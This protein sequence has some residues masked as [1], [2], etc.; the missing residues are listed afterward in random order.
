M[1]SALAYTQIQTIT[2]ARAFDAGIRVF[3]VNPAYSSG[4]GQYKFASR[5]GMSGHTAAIREKSWQAC[6]EQVGS[7]FPEDPSSACSAQAV[8]S[9]PILP[10]T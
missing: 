4:I 2:R 7:G 3:E 6:V 1:L 5:Y 10:G 9:F 8:G